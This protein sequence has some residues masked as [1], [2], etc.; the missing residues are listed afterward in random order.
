[1]YRIKAVHPDSGAVEW[2][3]PVHLRLNTVLDV[4]DRIRMGTPADDFERHVIHAYGPRWYLSAD[5]PPA[6]SG[7]EDLNPTD[8]ILPS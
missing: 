7:V 2:L 4:L 6:V 8:L 1:M 3:G 5:H